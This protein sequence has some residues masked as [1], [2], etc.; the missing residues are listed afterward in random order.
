[1]LQVAV[2][3]WT[4]IIC[5]QTSRS[6]RC[7]IKVSYVMDNLILRS[8]RN[9]AGLRKKCN[10]TRAQEVSTEAH[11]QEMFFEAEGELTKITSC[12]HSDWRPDKLAKPP[13]FV[14]YSWLC[15]HC[16]NLAEGGCPLLPFHFYTLCQY[17]LGHVACRNL[18]WQGLCY[19]KAQL[20]KSM[21]KVV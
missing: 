19:L 4:K 6:W 8:P 1:M 13:F 7:S 5:P 12:W 18:P 17:F 15:H 16:C 14:A 20:Y 10:M 9:C 21:Q 11:W 3:N 2:G